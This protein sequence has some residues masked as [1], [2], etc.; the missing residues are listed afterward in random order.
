MR[1][2]AMGLGFVVLAAATS[3][4]A[5]VF[6]VDDTGEIGDADTGNGVCATVGGTCTLRAA[7]EQ[8]NALGGAA[9]TVVLPA[10]TYEQGMT[11]PR[12]VKFISMN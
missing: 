5:A 2:L 3:V 10:G 9:H 12:F 6:T 7:L 1:A 4:P 8:A 11:L